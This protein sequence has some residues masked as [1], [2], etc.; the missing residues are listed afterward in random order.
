MRKLV[1]RETA[2]RDLRRIAGYTKSEWGFDQARRYAALLRRRIKA[3]RTFPLRH[4][5]VESRPSLREMRVGQHV[6]FYLVSDDAIEI[7]RILHV[8]SDFEAR[9]R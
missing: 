6:V 5:E 1:Y 2:A 4:P 3:L 9:L 8:A 7:V